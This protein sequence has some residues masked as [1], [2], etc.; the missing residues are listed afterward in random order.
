[1]QP[2][3]NHTQLAQVTGTVT[4]ATTTGDSNYTALWIS[5]SAAAAAA[6]ITA[7]V[8]YSRKRKSN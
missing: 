6:A 8:V 7:G 4:K 2:T 3:E 1:M 5:F